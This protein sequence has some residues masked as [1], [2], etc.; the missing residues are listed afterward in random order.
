M[1]EYKKLKPVRYF[2]YPV[3]PTNRVVDIEVTSHFLVGEDSPCRLCRTIENFLWQMT[4]LS[5]LTEKHATGKQTITE[6][7]SI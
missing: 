5:V 7:D 1:Y 4:K 2:V 6:T 3:I